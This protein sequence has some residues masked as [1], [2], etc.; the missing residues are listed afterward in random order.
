MFMIISWVFAFIVLIKKIV[1]EKESYIKESMRIL[2]VRNSQHW[3]AW[4]IDAFFPMAIISI[5]LSIILI[6]SSF[7]LFV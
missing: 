2:G 4:F 1:T 7:L 6:V 3:I 5:F